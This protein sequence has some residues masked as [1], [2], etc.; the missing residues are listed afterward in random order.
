MQMQIQ[1]QKN[2]RTDCDCGG[3]GLRCVKMIALP[4]YYT[5]VA[6]ISTTMIVVCRPVEYI[7]CNTPCKSSPIMKH[8]FE[9]IE[10][11]VLPH[12]WYWMVG[13]QHEE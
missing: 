3:V 2:T 5:S 11:V 1:I 9:L 8:S 6:A 13:T 4:A 12:G 10:T 7:F